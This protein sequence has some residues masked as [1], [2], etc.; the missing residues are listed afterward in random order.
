M[1]KLDIG[2][3]G[4]LVKRQAILFRCSCSFTF[5]VKPCQHVMI[6]TRVFVH[7][8]LY[9]CSV[10]F[11]HSRYMTPSSTDNQ[12]DW[13]PRASVQMILMVLSIFFYEHQF[14]QP[15]AD[16]SGVVPISNQESKG[17]ILTDLYTHSYHQEYQALG[18]PLPEYQ[19]GLSSSRDSE[20][21]S[22][23]HLRL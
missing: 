20:E 16:Y 17:L 12:K 10:F 14:L 2:L 5:G 8:I 19:G 6:D 22:L 7:S 23:L 11:S 13:L 3:N 15:F 18:H 4:H 9:N 1:S 21:E